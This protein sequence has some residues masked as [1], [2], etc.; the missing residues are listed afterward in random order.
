ML[1]IGNGESRKGFDLTKFNCLTVGCNAIIRETR[2][3]NVV[4]CDKRM[5]LEASRKM[6]NNKTAV[7]TRHDWMS[8]F[9]KMHNLNAIPSL[10]Y[11]GGLKQDNHFHWGSGP[12][13]V[14]V[15]CKLPGRSSEVIHMI[16][17]DLY[18]NED[19]KINNIYKGTFNYEDEDSNGVNPSFWIYQIAKVMER[20]SKREFR[21]Y[22]KAD[23]K[24]PQSWKALDNV[25][26]CPLGDNP[27][28]IESL[29][30]IIR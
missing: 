18:P 8:Q 12:Y 4:C 28:Q 23:W 17:F 7:W 13:A 29:Y 30:G 15:G 24:M 2:V 14:Y 9:P 3:H 25:H 1:I 11:E 10:W 26:F 19:G 27:K 16:G 5:V 6:I 21:V 20:F 22:N